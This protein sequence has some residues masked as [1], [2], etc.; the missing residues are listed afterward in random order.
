MF[1]KTQKSRWLEKVKLLLI[2]IK[3][4]DSFKAADTFVN[5]YYKTWNHSNGGKDLALFYGKLHAISHYQTFA[6]PAVKPNPESA[7]KPDITING[8]KVVSNIS[9]RHMPSRGP[10]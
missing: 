6:N 2:L 8:N 10:H 5:T 9:P 3:I 4:T 7:L 1:L